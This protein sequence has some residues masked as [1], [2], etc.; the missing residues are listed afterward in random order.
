[1]SSLDKVVKFSTNPPNLDI[2]RSTF[3][4][5]CSLKLSFNNGELVPIFVDPVNPGDTFDFRA[6]ALARTSTPLFPVMDNAYIDMN[7][8]FVP[9][10]LVWDDFQKLM[11]ENTDTKWVPPTAV[12]V[13]H[14]VMN[15]PYEVGSLA[16]YMG[17]PLGISGSNATHMSLPFRAYALIW[18]EWYRDQ[19]MQDPI[20]IDKGSSDMDNTWND[21]IHDNGVLRGHKLKRVAKF[22]DYF[23]SCLPSPQKAAPV[24]LP[25]GA[26]AP[27]LARTQ[28]VTNLVNPTTIQIYRDLNSVNSSYP[29]VTD[30]SHSYNIT[31][32]PS[33]SNLYGRVSPTGVPPSTEGA[34]TPINLWTDL[35]QATA[36]TVNQIR[37]AFQLQKLFERDARGGTRY[38]EIIKSHFNVD[39]AD[40]RLQRPEYLGGSRTPL[41]ISQVLQTSSTDSVSPLGST[42]AFSLTVTK[43]ASFNKSFTEHGLIIGLINCRTEQT[44]QQ[45]LE[46]FWSRRNRFDFPFPALAH[47]GE[48]AIFKKEI[49]MTGDSAQDEQVFGYQEK[50]ADER[51][52][53]NRVS[54][55]MRSTSLQPLDYAHYGIK[56]TSAP[57]LNSAFIEEPTEIMDRTLAV[58]SA[59]THQILADI[60]FKNVCS[61]AMPL[62]GIPGLVDHF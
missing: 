35:T 26:Y 27:V 47:I 19:N 28:L 39:S 33:D 60:S 57:V 43:D 51:Y 30:G 24:N 16:D 12:Q 13:P 44:Y 34:V 62:F 7:F 10:R 38:R 31:K 29:A 9:Y 59:V 40:S 6:L 50:D 46:R 18:N 49:Y 4:R 37:T 56:F 42:S 8:F 3:N 15:Q 41:N 22:H 45:G 23:T 1:M 14:H 54:G 21:N 17:I 32:Y 52:K 55:Y 11:G 53:P 20:H 25:L 61:R 2:P 58:T 48:Q 5:D 36:S